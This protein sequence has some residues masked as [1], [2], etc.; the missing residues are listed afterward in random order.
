M[1]TLVAESDAASPAMDLLGFF[2]AVLL[3]SADLADTI[4]L[5]LLMRG[6]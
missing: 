1:G 2:R 3:T 4:G 6:N 5:S